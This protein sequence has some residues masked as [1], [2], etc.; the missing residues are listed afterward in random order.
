[1]IANVRTEHKAVFLLYC[2]L[3]AIGQ[4]A[5]NASHPPLLIFI[6][7]WQTYAASQVKKP[8][9]WQLLLPTLY[10][11]LTSHTSFAINNYGKVWH[12]SVGMAMQFGKGD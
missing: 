11:N 7:W 5:E 12:K 8:C 10:S 4:Q 2:K 9:L 3:I 1:M 6:S